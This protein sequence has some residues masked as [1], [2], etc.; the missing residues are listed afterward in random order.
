MIFKWKLFLKMNSI[1]IAVRVLNHWVDLNRHQDEAC[2]H[3]G[4]PQGFHPGHLALV[5]SSPPRANPKRR[6]EDDALGCQGCGVREGSLSLNE[7]I[8]FASVL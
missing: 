3:D 1:Y 8:S 7:N 4:L 2:T 5:L 6:S